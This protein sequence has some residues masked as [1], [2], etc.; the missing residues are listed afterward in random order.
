M[1][2]Y[3]YYHIYY[4]YYLFVLNSIDGEDECVTVERTIRRGRLS[5]CLRN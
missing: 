4:Y 3:Y 2:Y 1:Y 5:P